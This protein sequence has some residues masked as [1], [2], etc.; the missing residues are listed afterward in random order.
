MRSRLA[1]A[2]LV[3]VA[4]LVAMLV[5]GCKSSSSPSPA[6]VTPTDTDAAPPTD[7]GAAVPAFDF[8]AVHDY[9]FTGNWKSEGLVILYKGQRVDERYAAGFTAESP[10]ILYSASKTVGAALVGIAIKEGVL[11]LTD[12]VC[13]YTPAPAGA[14]PTLCDTTVDHLLHMTSGLAWAEDYGSDPAASNVLQMLYGNQGDMGAY[15]MRRPRKAPP[16]TVFNYSSGDSTLLSRVLK[17]ALA[18]VG[19]EERAYANEKLFG[20][21]GLKSAV[22]EA[23]RSGTLVFSSSCFM[24]VRDMAKFGQLYLDDGVS[25]GARVLPEGWVK[26]SITPSGPVSAPSPRLGDGGYRSDGGSYGAGIWLNAATP[27]STP[28]Q[29]MYPDSPVDTYSFEGHW[30]Q[31]IF[32]VPSRSLVIARTGFDRDVVFDPNPMVQ[33]TVAAID[34][35]V[36][37][38]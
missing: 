14:D 16:N 12:S 36:R 18:A 5:A 24:T 7:A 8:G 38:K 3:L 32:I 22:F 6:T 17:G 25:S 31:K 11:A 9:L 34:K 37:G 26:Y 23:D 1:L 27:T 35:G 29:L 4:M 30:G 15:V 20:P 2:V 13:K 21:A 19:K 28:D 10:H 33:K